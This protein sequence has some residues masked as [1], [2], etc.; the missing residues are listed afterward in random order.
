M[1]DKFTVK[2]KF[3]I[4][5]FLSLLIAITPLM[6]YFYKYMP[7]EETWSFLGIEFTANGFN[8]V[9][10]AFYYYFNKIVPLLLLVIWY[11]TS[12]NWWY[13]AILIPIAMYSFQFFN[14]LNYEN[15]KLD[16]NEILYVIAVTMVVVPIVYFIRVKLVD[17]HVHGIDLEAMDTELQIL[18]EKEELRKER[19]KLEQRQKTASKKM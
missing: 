12:R 5:G 14:V 19:E 18:K 9:S 7:L 17:K 4:E 2:K 3:I 1:K 11:I 13:H 16:E 8:D 6:F 10:D 15:S